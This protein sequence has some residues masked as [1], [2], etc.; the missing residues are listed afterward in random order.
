VIYFFN[1]KFHLEEK[2][3]ETGRTPVFRAAALGNLKMVKFLVDKGASLMQ[4][5][6]YN[7]G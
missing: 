4:K 2:D 3:P 1:D 6:M 5:D 7:S